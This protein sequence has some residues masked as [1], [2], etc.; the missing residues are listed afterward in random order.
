M[1]LAQLDKS[2]VAE[3]SINHEHISNLQDTKLLY[4]KSDTWIDS[5]GKQL[6]LKCTHTTLREKMV[7]P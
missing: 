4:A 5:S 2:A 1:R 3:H 7:S 6:N